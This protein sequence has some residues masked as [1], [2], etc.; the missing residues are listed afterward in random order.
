MHSFCTKPS[1]KKRISTDSNLNKELDL[2]LA[3]DL[4]NY[5]CLQ[6]KGLTSATAHG[7]VSSNGRVDLLC[8]CC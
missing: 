6:F 8:C 7:S 4:F 5:I 1:D 2:Y 3:K